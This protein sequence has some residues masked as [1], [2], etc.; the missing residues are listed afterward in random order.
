MELMRFS[1]AELGAAQTADEVSPSP[2]FTF[3]PK[4]ADWRPSQQ[5][6]TPGMIRRREF[7]IGGGRDRA[8][9]FAARR[10]HRSPTTSGRRWPA[11]PTSSPGA[12]N[13]GEDPAY[14][15]RRYERYEVLLSFNDLWT[16]AEKRA[17]LFTPREEF[18]LPEDRDQRLRRPLPRHRLR[19]HHHAA[20]H[21]GAHD[22]LA[23][24]P[25][26]DKVL[27]IGTGSGYQSALLTYLTPQVYTIE[28][29]PELAARTRGVYDR[30]IGAGYREYA[31]DRH[32]NR[33]RLLRLGRGGAVRQDHRHLRHRPHPAAAAATIQA[34]RDHGHSR[35]PARRAAH[36]E[37]GQ[38]GRRGRRRQVARSD[39]FGG[40]IIPFVPL[41]GGHQ[42]N[43]GAG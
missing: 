12:A 39:I 1:R 13:R 37:G 27:E 25:P 3:A 30:L 40:K 34:R 41:T 26:G 4:L 16:P 22:Q 19:R 6:G 5:N 17:F 31:V 14:L 24:S 18:V 2:G 7:L 36:P 11:R 15:A 10:A 33:R 32:P 42:T 28:I 20:G 43:D 29:I 38:D 21:H 9:G 8:L 23:R 35:R